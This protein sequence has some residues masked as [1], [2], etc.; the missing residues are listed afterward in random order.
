S[1]PAEARELQLPRMR[2]LESLGDRPNLEIHADA[3]LFHASQPQ[4]VELPIHG[5]D[6]CQLVK[7][8]R[9]AVRQLAEAVSVAI[10]IAELVE[11]RA[12]GRR[13]VRRQSLVSAHVSLDSRRKGLC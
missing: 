3:D 2:G 7:S 1:V 12:C 13:I 8:E 4:V 11:E 5:A 10:A 9:A 6:E